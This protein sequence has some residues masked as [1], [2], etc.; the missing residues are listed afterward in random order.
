MGWTIAGH[1]S[2]RH[3]HMQVQ[4]DS[5]LSLTFSDKHSDL[6]SKKSIS[7]DQRLIGRVDRHLGRPK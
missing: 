5:V 2:D 3:Y 1:K 6:N 4:G 7:P